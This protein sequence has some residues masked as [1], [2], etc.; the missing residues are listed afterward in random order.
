MIDAA[1]YHEREILKDGSMANVRAV[2]PDDKHRFVE[3][4]RHLHPESIYTRYFY[5]KKDLSAA[6]LRFATEVDFDKVVAL[7]VTLGEGEAE[8]IIAG[9]RYLAFDGE[10][11]RRAE[12]SFTV[13]DD[14]Q[15]QGIAG[16]L[17]QHLAE[18]GREKGL[19]RLEAEVLAENGAM[20]AVFAHSGLP[21][22]RHYEDGTVHVSLELNA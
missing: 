11:P 16:H 19:Q 5:Q 9:G 8:T 3:A 2:R 10:P 4:F 13:E 1:N 22:Q 20:L 7:V 12:V 21:M 18:I 15:H 6:D 14:Y 17:L